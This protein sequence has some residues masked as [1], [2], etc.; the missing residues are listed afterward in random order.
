MAIIQL[1]HQTQAAIFG[2]DLT[3]CGEFLIALDTAGLSD[4][5]TNVDDKD[6]WTNASYTTD[7][8]LTI[9]ELSSSNE[10]SADVEQM[11]CDGDTDYASLCV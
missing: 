9:A 8:G 4:T 7:T 6:A 2:S 5:C 11:T 3:G 10:G 1:L